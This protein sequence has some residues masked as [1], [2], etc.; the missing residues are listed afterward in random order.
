MHCLIIDN[1]ENVAGFI[2]NIAQDFDNITFNGISEDYDI[3]LNTILKE[4]PQ[5]IIINIETIS[6]NIPQLLYEVHQC[7]L[8]K[9]KFLAISYH[10]ESAY[11]AYKYEFSDFLLKPLSEVSIRKSLLKFKKNN[12]LEVP[13]TLCLKSN[14]D[15]QYL[16]TNEILYLKADNNTTDF[17]MNN[18]N[19]IGA[20]KTLKVFENLLP[21]SFLRIHKSY[22]VNT[23][24]ISRIHYGKS[25]CLINNEHRIPFT[26]TFIKNIDVINTNL[27]KGALITL[28]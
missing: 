15:F 27:S 28:N 12:L 18:G 6:I 11:D 14:K 8:H 1:D 3:S 21:K 19:V 22:I 13:E 26:K 25:I 23:N 5:L 16:N 4:K 24:Q 10:K 17:F 7:T 20:Y 9:V 2:K